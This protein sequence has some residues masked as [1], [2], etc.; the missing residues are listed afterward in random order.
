MEVKNKKLVLLTVFLFISIFILGCTEEDILSSR[1]NTLQ[2]TRQ[3]VKQLDN[4]NVFYD[5]CFSPEQNC[6]ELLINKIKQAEKN[7][8]IMIY[9]FTLEDVAEELVKKYDKNV[10]V[11]VIFDD[12][13]AES[14]YSVDEYLVRN[15]IAVKY[16]RRKGLQHN[17]VLIVDDKIV[18][19]GSYNYSLSATTR[20]RENL[21]CT[22]NKKV[23]NHYV[24]NFWSNWN[25]IS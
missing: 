13:Q 25:E 6:K 20:N 8:D 14:K 3:H 24:Q 10:A 5:T 15:G 7:I 4:N 19:F 23:V 9:S 16:D 2:G 22:N 11:Y 21:F 17:K 12:G 18:C 1:S